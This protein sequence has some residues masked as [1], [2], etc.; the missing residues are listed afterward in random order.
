[1][2]STWDSRRRKRRGIRYF[3]LLGFVRSH[4]KVQGDVNAPKLWNRSI[5]QD[6]IPIAI[7]PGKKGGLLTA[8]RGRDCTNLFPVWFNELI[9]QLWPIL[10]V[11][12]GAAVEHLLVR[13]NE[14]T[15]QPMTQESPST[16]MIDRT[17]HQARCR[18]QHYSWWVCEQSICCTRKWSNLELAFLIEDFDILL[19]S[20]LIS[21]I[22]Y[23]S[24]DTS[25]FISDS[26]EKCCTDSCDPN[27]SSRKTK[28]QSI[29]WRKQEKSW[30]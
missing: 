29:R 25:L 12:G 21:S 19:A 23:S 17:Y 28:E 22:F 14:R 24:L 30:K 4:K 27:S 13:E 15:C 7:D 1:M 9:P 16:S 10:S 5:P 11:N 18:M 8:K 20:R 6:S 2:L 3:L 26:L